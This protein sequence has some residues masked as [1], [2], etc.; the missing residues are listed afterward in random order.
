MCNVVWVCGPE[1]QQQKLF[2]PGK[3]KK[4][5]LQQLRCGSIYNTD[6]F[7]NSLPLILLPRLRPT[8]HTF[9]MVTASLGLLYFLALRKVA[10][11]FVELKE[12]K[13]L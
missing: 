7:P 2:L 4:L 1:N 11:S 9:S 13:L 5:A 3:L 10:F 8:H 6:M 12:M